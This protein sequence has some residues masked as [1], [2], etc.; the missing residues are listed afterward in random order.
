MAEFGKFT[1]LTFVNDNPPALNAV[2]LNEMQRVLNL[3]DDE[4]SR[5]AEQKFKFYK[6]YFWQRNC[7]FIDDFNSVTGWAADAS[8]TI[9]ADTTNFLVGIQSMK[10]L[11]NDNTAGWIGM[12]KALIATNLDT[13]NDASSANDSNHIMWCF[14]ISDKT[15]F[16]HIQFKLGTDNSN[17][18]AFLYTASILNNGW[19]CVYDSK[20]SAIVAGSPDWANITYIRCEATTPAGSINAYISVQLCMLYRYNPDTNTYYTPFQKYLS[21]GSF[22]LEGPEIVLDTWAY[23]YDPVIRD[24]GIMMLDTRTATGNEKG[25]HIYCSIINFIAKFEVYCKSAGS[26]PSFTWAI[27]TNNYIEGYIS[28]DTLYL[29]FVEAGATTSYN[30]ALTNALI[31]N[32]R[33][34]IG[35]EKEG[36][37]ARIILFKDGENIKI[38]EQETSIALA[39]DGCLYLGCKTTGCNGFLTNYQVSNRQI[40]YDSWDTPKVVLKTADQI[41]NNSTAFINC[42]D[43]YVDLPPNSM[44]LIDSY[45]ASFNATTDAADIKFDWALTGDVTQLKGKHLLTMP[46]NITSC[47][48]GNLKATVFDLTTTNTVGNDGTS[49][50]T[51]TRES[52]LVYTKNIGGRIQLRFAQNTANASDTIVDNQS[53]M[54]VTKLKK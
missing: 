10:F 2:N 9:S 54:I 15:K 46:T 13:F 31:L 8:T 36:Q 51:L 41:V 44:F 52:F 42:D 33:Y 49:S 12:S 24:L 28:S 35:F 40:K 25:L 27:D 21:G 11:E 39:A 47:L 5:S 53:F 17:N 7:K 6:E 38:L 1:E 20:D 4:L 16:T 43:M 34:Q 19:N 14:Y 26:S 30:I 45:I 32:E 29:D 22:E 3:S 18:Y 23:Y 48:D 50:E 37:T